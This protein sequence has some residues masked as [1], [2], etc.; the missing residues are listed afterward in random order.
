MAIA[1]SFLRRDGISLREPFVRPEKRRC[2][3]T[4]AGGRGGPRYSTIPFTN[5]RHRDLRAASVTFDQT[6]A[7]RPA[8]RRFSCT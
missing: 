8:P 4:L 7:K 1:A 5:D 3:L 2:A 6:A